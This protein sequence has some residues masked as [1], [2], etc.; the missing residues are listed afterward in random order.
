MADYIDPVFRKKYI[1][2][3][4][5]KELINAIFKKNS[6]AAKQKLA[7]NYLWLAFQISEKYRDKILDSED[8]LH[9]AIIYLFIAI[10]QIGKKL[11]KKKFEDYAREYIKKRMKWAAE[12][13]R[14]YTNI[15][16]EEINK[17]NKKINEMKKKYSEEKIHYFSLR[18]M[19]KLEKKYNKNK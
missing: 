13:Q 12:D 18:E 4:R 3:A 16:T 15:P 14:V 2:P 1:D 8:R 5:E 11:K 10:G 9:S 19:E 17:L 6:K 7:R